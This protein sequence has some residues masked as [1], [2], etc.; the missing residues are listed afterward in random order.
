MSSGYVDVEHDANDAPVM[1]DTDAN[2]CTGDYSCMDLR[3]NDG[4]TVK[5]CAMELGWCGVAGGPGDS[6]NEDQDLYCGE[7]TDPI[8]GN[9]QDAAF[10]VCAEQCWYLCSVPA[11]YTSDGQDHNYDCADDMSCVQGPADLFPDGV[12][13]C[14]HGFDAGVV[15]TEDAGSDT[16]AAQAEDAGFNED[17]G[18]ACEP[19]AA[20]TFIGVCE[21]DVLSWCDSDGCLQSS[22]CT[23]RVVGNSA[24]HCSE[25]SADWGFD[26][27]AAEGGAC[28]PDYPAQPTNPNAPTSPGCDPSVG[29][30]NPATFICGSVPDGGFPVTDAGSE[31]AG[32]TC[33]PCT[34]DNQEVPSSGSCAGDQLVWCGSDNC[35]HGFDCADTS[36]SCSEVTVNS[37]TDS[38]P[39]ADCFGS[40][41]AAC[42]DADTYFGNL[43][44]TY[45]DPNWLCDP[46]TSCDTSSNTCL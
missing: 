13:V 44:N 35:L 31:D 29:A 40:S 32:S 46:D 3:T 9:D 22:D 27:L 2:V 1:C 8:A 25:F 18:P 7:M 26:C 34:L 23:Q 36:R 20:V 21:Q 30:C 45:T 5:A 6:C 28:N 17:A 39:W 15:T 19:C 16:D 10:A 33:Q 4:R 37:G 24:L 42:V 14:D 38:Y 43:E 11:A 41:G 12:K